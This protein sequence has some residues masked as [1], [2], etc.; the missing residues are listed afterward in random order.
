MK[1][2]V[3]FSNA[4]ANIAEMKLLTSEQLTRIMDADYANAIRMLCDYGYADGAF[5]GE[6]TDIDA[7]I[8]AETDKLNRFVAENCPNKYM[9]RI[10]FNPYIY[11][12]IKAILK[13]E[14]GGSKSK[15][16][17]LPIDVAAAIDNDD[18]SSLGKIAEKAINDVR[19]LDDAD[20]K[21]IDII[22]TQAMYD[23]SIAQA[24]RSKDRMLKD[25]VRGEIDLTNIITVLRSRKLGK[26]FDYAAQMIIAGGEL[27][28]DKLESL[29]N[30]DDVEKVIG[31][32]YHD[33]VGI[34]LE[35]EDLVALENL[36]DNYLLTV[37]RRKILEKTSL[38]PFM[39]Y[40]LRRLTEYKVVKMI[41][42]CIKNDVRSEI[43][44]RLRVIY[45]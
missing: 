2:S 45:D 35:N 3:I 18:I 37:V 16:Y 41:L 40:Y 1:T 34:A 33:V 28:L 44:R 8:G 13:C 20:G 27:G 36:R 25:F 10:I 6:V 22:V 26:T 7:F 31:N 43:T 42:T 12:N 24:R 15:L 39:N 23:D 21:R 4:T 38:S 17:N 14:R 11:N 19:A 29:Y 9:E 32:R 5:D 30:A